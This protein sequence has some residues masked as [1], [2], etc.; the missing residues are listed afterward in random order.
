[1]K[2]S[3]SFLKNMHISKVFGLHEI[4]IDILSIMGDVRVDMLGK[5]Y[6]SKGNFG[7]VHWKKM[8]ILEIQG[9]RNVIFWIQE[10]FWFDIS[11]I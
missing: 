5:P 11:Q 1:M 7:W 10:F 9:K 6:N 2:L 8:C 4:F 3:F